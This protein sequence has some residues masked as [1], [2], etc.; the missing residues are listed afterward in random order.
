MTTHGSNPACFD[1]SLR[2][3]G[4]PGQLYM[5]GFKALLLTSRIP[6]TKPTYEASTH[7]C[8]EKI[9]AGHI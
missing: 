3:D 2:H 9:C 5:Y 8:N 1:G 7:Q 4:L 6:G